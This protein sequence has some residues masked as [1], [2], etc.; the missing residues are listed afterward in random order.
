VRAI[1]SY[2]DFAPHVQRCGAFGVRAEHEQSGQS[3]LAEPFHPLPGRHPTIV[4]SPLEAVSACVER[5]HRV[6]VGSAAGAPVSLTK[7]LAEHGQLNLMNV[8]GERVEVVHIHTEGSGAYMASDLTSV[9]RTRNF[10]TGPNARK[11]IAAGDAEYAPIFLSEIPLL[12]RRGYLPLDVAL[13]TVSPPD[14]HGF[15][16]L[17]VSVDI[18][19]SAIQC[20]KTIVAVVNKNVS[21]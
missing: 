16:S 3:C 1:R 6:F 15:V 10:F 2:Y 20:S 21:C 14:E 18:V 4:E 7:A 12:F 5:G 9:F 11:P 8:P 13:I 19:R 17:G